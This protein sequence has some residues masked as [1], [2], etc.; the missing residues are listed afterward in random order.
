MFSE[1]Y[2]RAND[3]VTLLIAANITMANCS[4]PVTFVP[5]AGHDYELK[6]GLKSSSLS[7]VC[8]IEGTEITGGISKPLL[9]LRKTEEC[10]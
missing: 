5:E 3:P 6:L 4:F 7:S 9:S 1:F 8:S 10:P 2:V